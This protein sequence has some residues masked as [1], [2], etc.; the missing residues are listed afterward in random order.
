MWRWNEA[1]SSSIIDMISQNL[2]ANTCNAQST[3]F[4]YDWTLELFLLYL[5]YFILLFFIALAVITMQTIK[6]SKMLRDNSRQT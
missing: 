5:L 3:C 4:M 2:M 6:N 1:D